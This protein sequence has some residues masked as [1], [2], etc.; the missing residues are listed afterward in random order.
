MLFHTHTSGPQEHL[1]FTTGCY[2]NWKL[3]QVWMLTCHRSE[4]EE[5]CHKCQIKCIE[6]HSVVVHTHRPFLH[7]FLY[8][9]GAF[10]CRFLP[11]CVSGPLTILLNG[12]PN[13]SSTR[14][15]HYSPNRTNPYIKVKII[16]A[17]RDHFY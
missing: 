15:F 5:F 3:L 16:L 13:L 12:H 6:I 14:M 7:T 2:S 11:T 9:L 1:V 8:L 4:M 10:F 17:K